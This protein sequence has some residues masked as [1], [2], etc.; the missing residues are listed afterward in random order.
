MPPPSVKPATPVV[1][2]SPPVVARP[3]CWASWSTSPQVAPP[4]TNARR[5]VGV[6]A[7]GPAA[8]RGRSPCLRRWSR[9]PATLWPPPR[10]ATARSW[11]RAKPSAAI[12]SATPV[13]R[14]DGGRHAVVVCAVPDPLRL[15]VAVVA[16]QEQVA[17]Q[18]VAQLLNCRLAENRRECLRHAFLLLVGDVRAVLPTDYLRPICA[19]LR[20]RGAE[21]ARAQSST[22][23]GDPGKL[24]QHRAYSY[25]S[26]PCTEDGVGHGDTERRR[27]NPGHEEPALRAPVQGILQTRWRGVRADPQGAA[28]I[29]TRWA[30]DCS[31]DPHALIRGPSLHP[32]RQQRAH[33]H[34]HDP[35]PRRFGEYDQT[36]RSACALDNVGKIDIRDNVYIGY[37][38]IILPGV[39]IGPNAIVSAGS[40]VR[41]NVARATWSPACLPS[42]SGA[43][44]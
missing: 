27:A 20:G 35:R 16:G 42:A 24:R 22:Y 17:A 3:N 21:T 4:P 26:Q 14:A 44:T 30:R 2:T 37:G 5:G 33:R 13:Q 23:R 7:D 31:I 34:L 29:S 40:V 1:E 18:R 15:V 10:T 8:A 41:S 32:A 19:A 9:S 28:A 12:T 11:L 6:D 36:A 25:R 38:A 43:W 39:T